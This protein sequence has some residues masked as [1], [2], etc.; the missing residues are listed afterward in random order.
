MRALPYFPDGR[1]AVSTYQAPARH[2]DAGSLAYGSRYSISFYDW[3][4]D[5]DAGDDFDVRDCRRTLMLLRHPNNQK[6][7]SESAHLNAF[8]RHSCEMFSSCSVRTSPKSSA[9]IETARR[10]VFR[11]P[12]GCRISLYRSS[13]MPLP[14]AAAVPACGAPG[15]FSWRRPWTLVFR[16]PR[17]RARSRTS[18]PRRRAGCRS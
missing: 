12:A 7:A 14:L 16:S 4:C 11:S 1:K 3:N 6:F 15:G 13:S 9:K 5:D 2:S 17:Q 10:I 8:F 18:A